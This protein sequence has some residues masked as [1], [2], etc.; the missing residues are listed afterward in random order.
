[1]TTKQKEQY[2]N[3]TEE[4]K[5]IYDSVMSNFPATHHES[6]IDVAWQGGVKWDFIS[7]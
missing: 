6:A 4:E 3:L 1:M 7:K 5:K 2:N